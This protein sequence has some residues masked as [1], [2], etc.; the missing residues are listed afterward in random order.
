M[1]SIFCH[2]AKAAPPAANTLRFE[3]GDQ[4]YSPVTAGVGSSGT[5]KKCE[6]FPSNVWDWTNSN[7]DWS[8]T[9]NGAF[10]TT[11]P[12]VEII[13]AGDT[14][15]ITNFR[16]MFYLNSKLL[17]CIAFDT[18][19]MKDAQAMFRLCTNLKTVPLFDT[20]RLT[21]ARNMF[22]GCSGVEGGAF[23]LYTQMS[24]Q[25]TPPAIHISTFEGCG[26]NTPTGAAELAQIPT[27][28]GGTKEEA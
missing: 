7:S 19:G 9:F 2:K 4:S 27:S 8:S 10:G 28:W 21:N 1:K 15:S 25:A 5:W 18:S 17:S 11:A 12:D 3:F 16:S 23:A 6:W 20:S 13:D 14:S 22:I 24:T 26:S